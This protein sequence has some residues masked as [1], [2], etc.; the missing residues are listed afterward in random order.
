MSAPYTIGLDYGTNSVRTQGG[1]SGQN[2]TG[3][4]LRPAEARDQHVE[5]HKTTRN[6]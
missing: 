1:G 2:P 4:R 3:T 6:E 5:I